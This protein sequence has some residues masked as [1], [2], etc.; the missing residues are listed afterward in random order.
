MGQRDVDVPVSDVDEIQCTSMAAWHAWLAKNH[1]SRA[2]VWWITHKKA[3][4]EPSLDYDEMVC[5]ALCWGWIDSKVARVDELRTKTYLTPRRPTSRWSASNRTR[6][7]RL[8]GEGRMR[9]PGTGAVETAKASGHW[10]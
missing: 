6:V 5:E 4:P 3:S 1:S 10:E 7:E 2:G 8:M 9:V